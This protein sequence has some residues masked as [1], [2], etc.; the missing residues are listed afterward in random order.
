MTVALPPELM[1]PED[2][3]ARIAELRTQIRREWIRYVI[4]NLIVLGIPTIVVAILRTT[5]R[6][7]YEGGIAYLVIA[8]IALVGLIL[9]TMVVRIG[10]LRKELEPLEALEST[11]PR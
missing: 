1:A 11:R 4:T 7:G 8:N 6:V 9:F 2:R 3:E 5:E 10:P